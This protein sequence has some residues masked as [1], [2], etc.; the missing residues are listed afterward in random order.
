MLK[1][2]E[3]VSLQNT[4]SKL[5]RDT[6]TTL[7]V[8]HGLE[9]ESEGQGSHMFVRMYVVGNSLYQILVV[10]PPGSP[11]A[12]ASRF[13]DSFKLIE[14]ARRTDSS[15]R[16][17][18]MLALCAL[19]AL[20][21]RL[22]RLRRGQYSQHAATVLVR[23]RKNL[24][25][26]GNWWYSGLQSGKQKWKTRF[27]RPATQWHYSA[28]YT[29]SPVK[30]CINRVSLVPTGCRR[31]AVPTIRLHAGNIPAGT[32]MAGFCGNCGNTSFRM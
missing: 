25:G 15:V 24:A 22:T 32:T 18:P 9:F 31:S 6:K 3:Y 11:Y 29:G 19:S 23:W 10:Y 16:Q 17:D 26:G 8:Y 21:G 4:N 13:L 27:S 30:A 1:S 14:R 7:G 5:I 12:D 20:G 28:R 2:A